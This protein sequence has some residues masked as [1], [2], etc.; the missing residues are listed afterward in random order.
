MIAAGFQLFEFLLVSG[1][2]LLREVGAGHE[3]PKR[4]NLHLH[5]F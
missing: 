2:E 4:D 1:V 5:L 3:V